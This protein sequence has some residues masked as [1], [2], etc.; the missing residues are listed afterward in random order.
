LLII[1]TYNDILQQVS[2]LFA[3][4]PEAHMNVITVNNLSR[5]FT[6]YK[7]EA[8]KS[9]TLSTGYNYLFTRQCYDNTD[10]TVSSW[11]KSF[12]GQFGMPSGGIMFTGLRVSKKIYL[13]Q[14][15]WLGVVDLRYG[16]VISY[17]FDFFGYS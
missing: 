1:Q 13:Y 7:K 5:A 15:I 12:F 17:R 11:W 14:K 9:R 4:A 16:E 2:H 10:T 6:Y 8:G 3:L